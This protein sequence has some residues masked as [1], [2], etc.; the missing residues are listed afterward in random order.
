MRTFSFPALAAAALIG[1]L[2]AAAAERDICDGKA[3]QALIQCIEAAARGVP[4]KDAPAAKPAP[5]APSAPAQKAAPAAGPTPIPVIVA[6]SEDCTGKPRDEM[7]RCLA[8]G[9]RLAPSAAVVGPSAAAASTAPSGPVNCDGRA[10]E[11]LRR[12]VEAAAR[13]A[14]PAIAPGAGAPAASGTG[15]LPIIPCTGYVAA[16]QPLCMHRN[17]AISECRNRKKYPEFD[18]CMR[19]LMSNAPVPAAVADCTKLGQTQRARCE[20]RNRVHP[21]CKGEKTGYFAC[22]EQKLGA[23]AVAKR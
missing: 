16:D 15:H 6:P 1:A 3:G 22:L 11:E 18:V 8:A 21:A 13:D 14:P 9:G 5:A 7:R 10:G 4:Q 19:S 17:S 2:P 12:C 20:A 23:D